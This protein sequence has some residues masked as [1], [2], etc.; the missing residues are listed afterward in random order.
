MKYLRS[1]LYLT[2]VTLITTSSL[3]KADADDS[4][5]LLV[6]PTNGDDAKIVIGSKSY[7][8]PITFEAGF[9]WTDVKDAYHIPPAY[10]SLLEEGRISI[11]IGCSGA[12]F[13]AHKRATR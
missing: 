2:V 13:T 10:A 6:Y 3:S 9:H 12:S 7:L 5:R 11:Y 4:V 8:V 1:L